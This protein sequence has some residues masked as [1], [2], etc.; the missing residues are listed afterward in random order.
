MNEAQPFPSAILAEKSVVSCCLQDE[1]LYRQAKAEGIDLD[2]FH[3]PQ[4]RIVFEEIGQMKR[5]E[6]GQIDLVTIVQ[7]LNEK[8]ILQRAGGPSEVYS[9]FGFAP[10]AAGWTQWV[11][12]LREMKA[13]RLALRSAQRLSETNDSEE[14]IT[15]AE[16]TLKALRA[17]VRGPKRA[18][19]A[20]E[21]TREFV[22]RLTAANAAGEIP[23]RSTGLLAIDAVSGG[24]KPGEFWVI[25]GKPSRGKSVLMIQLACEFI[26]RG[27]PV[28]IFSLEMMRHEIIGRMVSTLGRV[29]YGTI[30][31]PKKATKGDLV[32]I[33]RSVAE[34]AEAPFW[35]D[36]TANQNTDTILSE[37]I[38]LRDANGS[39]ALVVVDYLQL[40]R[41][42]RQRGESREEEVARVSGSL[43]QL[44][45]E[46]NC[47]VI[48]ATQLNENGQ[49]RESRAI[50]QD[51]DNL[52]YIVEDG[53]KVVKLRNGRRN[54][55]L[56]LFL[57]G[58]FQRFQEG[59]PVTT[60]DNE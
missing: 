19:E 40:V 59:K 11:Q 56:P 6:N 41:G 12:T 10:T 52:L 51:A 50:E 4:T 34:L 26:T 45:K 15:E 22:E 9:I 23:G 27:E 55:L 39:L 18:V 57:N 20:K 7:R 17:A 48:S 30:T 42:N 1:R 32:G 35:I 5:D 38:R 60:E 14:A 54:D 47:P 37:A 24:M 36:D 49:S 3:Y 58:D 25:G 33:Q 29:N 16:A 21:S 46:L 2:A 13:R 44:A 31:Q 28:A 43:K 53:I 8:D